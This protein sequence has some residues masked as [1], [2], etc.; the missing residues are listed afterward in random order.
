MRVQ[1]CSDKHKH[2]VHIEKKEKKEERL[3]KA[4]MDAYDSAW[5]DTQLQHV[6]LYVFR[7]HT[8]TKRHRVMENSDE[9]Q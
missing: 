4:A 3:T 5:N 8:H 9:N 2:T 6:N 7:T 1:F